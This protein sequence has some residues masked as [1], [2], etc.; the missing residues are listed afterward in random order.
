MK[1]IF[2]INFFISSLFNREIF[3]QVNGFEVEK[4]FLDKMFVISENRIDSITLHLDENLSK[5]YTLK[6]ENEIYTF[7]VWFVENG[8]NYFQGK[9]KLNKNFKFIDYQGIIVQNGLVYKENKKI[10]SRYDNFDDLIEEQI[11]IGDF[12][13]KVKKLFYQNSLLSKISEISFHSNKEISNLK[14][15]IYYYSCGKKF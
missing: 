2:L 9:F 7:S 14:I 1:K 12:D 10:T 5:I 6:L 4:Y 15:S 3:S 8:N 11:E 13:K